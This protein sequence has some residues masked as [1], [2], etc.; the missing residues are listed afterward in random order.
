[1]SILQVAR[2]CQLV[3]IHGDIEGG[4]DQVVVADFKGEIDQ[5]IATWLDLYLSD[6]VRHKL[7]L[8]A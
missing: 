3:T 4:L 2:Q 8:D 1:M 6:A 7:F 5:Q